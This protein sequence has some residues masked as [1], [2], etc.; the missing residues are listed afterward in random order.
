[1]VGTENESELLVL[2]RAMQF[3]CLQITRCCLTASAAARS[4][5]PLRHRAVVRTSFLF[6]SSSLFALNLVYRHVK[7]LR[8]TLR[9]THCLALLATSPT[10]SLSTAT[11]ASKMDDQLAFS[12]TRSSQDPWCRLGSD[13]PW[14]N[15]VDFSLCF[16]RRYVRTA[17]NA[18]R[19]RVLL[20][21]LNRWGGVGLKGEDV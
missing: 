14:W 11:R 5:P 8:S 7:S 2:A 19:G 12:M 20:M 16:R 1:M 9:T 13:D 3:R 6:S 10:A 18:Y 17:T 21:V 15:G 4:R